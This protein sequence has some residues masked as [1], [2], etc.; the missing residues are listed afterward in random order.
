MSL[1]VLFP[2]LAPDDTSI[3]W[4]SRVADALAGAVPGLEVAAGKP[5]FAGGRVLVFESDE[6]AARAA[7]RLL[8]LPREVWF[9]GHGGARAAR[10]FAPLPAA[11]C[12]ETGFGVDTSHFRPVAPICEYEDPL[13][14][15]V[16]QVKEAAR[17]ATA[18]RAVASLGEAPKCVWMHAGDSPTLPAFSHLSDLRDL[19]AQA[20]IQDRVEWRG[21]VPFAQ[22]PGF[23]ASAAAVIECTTGGAPPREIVEAMACGRPV[24]VSNPALASWLTGLGLGELVHDGTVPG[25]AAKLRE[26]LA[27]DPAASRALGARLATIARESSDLARLVRV[28]AEAAG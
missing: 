15:T 13:V 18:I 17:L 10:R 23:H 6:L 4:R 7:R 25:L 16:C 26:T 20:D 19:V 5:S 27:R 3:G 1:S 9:W 21:P 2:R 14:L 28:I 11:G 24:L 8:V 22:L 12:T